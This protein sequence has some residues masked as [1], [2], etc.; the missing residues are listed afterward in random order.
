VAE[1]RAVG[2]VRRSAAARAAAGVPGGARL[3]PPGC[4]ARDQHLP[5]AGAGTNPGRVSAAV[6]VVED[7]L[8]CGS[9][10]QGEPDSGVG[11]DR[12]SDRR[13]VG[14]R[15]RL[16]ALGLAGVVPDESL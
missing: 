3:G 10:G 8:P 15:E 6:P 5:G 2:G 4:H 1:R 7:Q 13:S 16:A 11:A 12:Q 9:G 14:E